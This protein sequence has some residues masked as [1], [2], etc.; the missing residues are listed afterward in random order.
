MTG[1]HVHRVRIRTWIWVLAALDPD[2]NPGFGYPKIKK[3]FLEQ[4]LQY[5]YSMSPKDTRETS[6]PLMRTFSTSK[7][8]FSSLF[9]SFLWRAIFAMLDPDTDPNE[10]GSNP[11]PELCH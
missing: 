2:T 4:N 5:V 1:I 3:S 7:Q 6:C 10:R 8:D 9:R 11:D